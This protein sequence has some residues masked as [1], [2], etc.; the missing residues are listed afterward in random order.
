MPVGDRNDSPFAGAL[1][2]TSRQLVHIVGIGGAGMS[3]IAEV[4]TAMGH[5]VSGSD[6]KESPVL[7][8]LRRLGIRVSVGHDA[9][10]VAG[11]NVLAVS[12]AVGADNDG[13]VEVQSAHRGGVPV[14]RRADILAA[15][16][17]TR[18][19]IAVSG[20]HGKTTTSAM[21][22]MALVEAGMQPSFIVGARI[23]GMGRGAAWGTGEWLVVEADESDGTFLELAPRAAVVTSVEPDHL[24]YYGKFDAL[25]AAFARFIADVA[26][27]CLVCGDDPVAAGLARDA[28]VLTY[29]TS[30]DATYRLTEV[31]LEADRSSFVLA[32]P[33]ST[34][35]ITVPLPGIHNA[36]NTAGA[37]SVAVA[38]G[39]PP[40]AVVRALAAFPGVSRRFEARG[41]VGGV[42][43]IDDYAHLPGEVSAALAAARIGSWRRIVCIFQPHRYSRTADLAADFAD[44]FATADL[45]VMT[46][47]YGAGEEPRPGITGKAIADAVLDADPTRQVAWLPDR[48]ELVK[49]LK[50][51]LHPGDLC[52]TLGAGD[53]TSLPDEL[54]VALAT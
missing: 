50:A 3:P 25:V 2:L 14:V 39:A 49:F 33:D 6:M 27:P 19:V 53:I 45:L 51:R 28:G 15:I 46:S 11:A 52:L 44:A 20:T 5:Q 8:R 48:G 30:V 47:I 38:I 10:N 54:M 43:F 21:L 29:G 36:L 18:S 40:A 16:A 32:G 26:G 24:A 42:T 9:E 1:D 12:T 22:A 17:A 23:A 35:D 37:A 4:L 13:N 41:A 31:N 7:D 34:L